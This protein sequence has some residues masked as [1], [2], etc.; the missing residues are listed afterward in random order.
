AKS[1]TCW[2]LSDADYLL[3]YTVSSR[4][5]ALMAQRQRWLLLP[6]TQTM[7]TRSGVTAKTPEKLVCRRT[8]QGRAEGVLSYF[9]LGDEGLSSEGTK[10]IFIFLTLEN[11]D[12]GNDQRAKK[13]FTPRRLAF[14]ESDKEASAK[15]LAKGF[16]N[17]FSLESFGTSDTYRQT[18][19]ASKSQRTP[20][21]NKEPTHLR[22][23][24]T[25]KDQS[26]TKEKARR[27]RSKFR[28][29]GPDTK[30][31]ARILNIKKDHLG[32][33]SAAAE[34]EEWPMLVWCKMFR[35]TL[36][37]AV[38]IWFDDLDPKSMDS[39]KELSQKFLEELSKQK[40][41]AKDPT[42]IHSIKRRKNEYLQAFMNRFKSESSHIK[43]VPPILRISA[44]MHG[45]GHPELAK[46]LNDKIPKMVDEIFERVRAFIRGEVAAGSAKNGP[47]LSGRQG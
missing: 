12:Q 26:I 3:S 24:R 2:Q 44:F 21:K 32:N 6:K 34:Q 29:K 10:L 31:Q 38:R 37:G 43:G 42:E 36:G 35:Q 7:L 45:H 40:R 5:T 15:S 19:S 30:K 16:F 28:G 13:K 46:K 22:R 39:F 1:C 18:R 9:Q 4:S 17:R 20:S 27:E 8:Y 33:F 11:H 25:L 47:S 23:L 14:A 41:Y